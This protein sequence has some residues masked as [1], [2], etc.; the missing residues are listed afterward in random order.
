MSKPEGCRRCAFRTV[1]EGFCPDWYPAGAKIGFFLEAPGG[2]EILESKPLVGK[3]GRY[4][5][6]HFIEP[7]G[8]TRSDVAIFNSIRCKPPMLQ[9]PTGR[10]KDHVLEVC[11]QYDNAHGEGWELKPGGLLNFAPNAFVV[12]LHPAALLRSSAPMKLVKAAVGRGVKLLKL[13]YRPLVCMGDKPMSVVAPWLKGGVK[14]WNG[15]WWLGQLEFGKPE[16]ADDG[17]PMFS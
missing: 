1:G 6:H 14:K 12:A 2:D 10:I 15:H 7:F 8:L 13:G 4:W 9:F 5:S 11:R 17:T 3:A 16:V